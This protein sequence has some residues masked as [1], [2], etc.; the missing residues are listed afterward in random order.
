MD[1]CCMDGCSKKRKCQ[2]LAK[3]PRRKN[4]FNFPMC[5][6]LFTIRHYG[7][8]LSCVMCHCFPYR[9]LCMFMIREKIIV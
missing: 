6:P 5:G 1:G 8:L 2:T 9:L 4:K 7:P 3:I